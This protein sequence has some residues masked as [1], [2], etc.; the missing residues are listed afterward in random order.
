[1]RSRS[2]ALGALLLGVAA[3]MVPVLPAAAA[4]TES[5]ELVIITETDVVT[6]DL[7]AVANR[8]II[9]GRVEGDLF[10][11]AGQDVRI[12]G[13]VTGSVTALA[14]EIVVTG[15]VGGSVRASA[16]SV[17]I[18]GEVGLDV[19]AASAAFELSSSSVV[20]GDV[21]LWAWD[22]EVLGAVGGGL[23]GSQRN[24]DLAGEI[25]GPI[26]IAASRVSIV[27]AFHA[28]GDLGYRSH[29]EA[30]GLDQAN[31]DGVVVHKA[32]MPPN[33]RLRA[34]ALVV[35]LLIAT[36]LTSIALLAAWGW[37][38]RTQKSLDTLR[39][40]PVRSF[41]TGAVV[42]F[43][44][45]VLLGVA[46]LLFQITPATAALPLLLIL[47]PVMFGLIG[48]VLFTSLVAGVPM[49]AW[50]GGAVARRT[51]IYGA[52][53]IGSLITAVIWLV[54]VVGWLVPLFVLTGGLGAWI[55]TFAPAET[56][57]V[58]VETASQTLL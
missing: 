46:I 58:P 16:P 28:G 39:K 8:V 22:A 56:D 4:Q 31:V 35:R 18:S 5:T 54:P 48:I 25:L 13:E 14:A 36:M 33:I 27:D 15:S 20:G 34:L 3:L 43:S 23:E 51:T 57:T 32:V 11:L 40:R 21:V 29:R 53:A 17:S 41:V 24:I 1:M 30:S 49:V 10:A 6:Q 38:N 2:R 19:L 44:P 47:V 7:Y 37:P 26:D 55:G 50:I 9:R 12:E 45:V 52:I 42:V